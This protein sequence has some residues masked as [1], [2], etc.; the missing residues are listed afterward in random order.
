[1]PDPTGRWITESSWQCPVCGNVNSYDRERCANCD[2]S[3]RPSNQE[4]IRPVDP[5]DVVGRGRRPDDDDDAEEPSS[6]AT[7]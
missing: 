1:M 4:P 3:V 6:S 2:R 7:G 5:L